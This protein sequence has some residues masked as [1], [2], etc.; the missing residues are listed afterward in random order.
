MAH[1]KEHAEHHS[2]HHAHHH[3]T[4]AEE[5]KVEN[6]VIPITIRPSNIIYPN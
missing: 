2:K 4:H 3:L 1:K 6:T 5:K